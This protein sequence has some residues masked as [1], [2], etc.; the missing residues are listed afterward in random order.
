[1]TN[2]NTS[3]WGRFN[4]L[5]F[6]WLPDKPHKHLHK[7]RLF[8]GTGSRR[9]GSHLR[10]IM[11]D[12]FRHYVS[13]EQALGKVLSA[14]LWEADQNNTAW[15]EPSPRDG[16]PIRELPSQISEWCHPGP[17][18]RR[19]SGLGLTSHLFPMMKQPEFRCIRLVRLFHQRL[20]PVCRS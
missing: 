7:Q 2:G 17:G 20:P 16:H 14:G 8:K 9:N 1:M 15:W 19:G 3:T 10:C 13:L 5:I 6:V 11:F 12:S 4:L 18:L